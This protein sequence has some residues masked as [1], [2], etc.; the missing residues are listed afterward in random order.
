LE[1]KEKCNSTVVKIRKISDFINLL[2]FIRISNCDWCLAID[3]TE[4]GCAISRKKLLLY[5]T[6][7]F[8]TEKDWRMDVACLHRIEFDY[9]RDVLAVF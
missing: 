7:Y 4:V 9:M 8:I 1:R 5:N 3:I 2:V 6:L